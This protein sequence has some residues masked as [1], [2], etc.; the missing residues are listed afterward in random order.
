MNHTQ[1]RRS[2][3]VGQVAI[4]FTNKPI[5]A[6][7]GIASVIAKFLEQIE[8]RSWVE[9]EV[10]I[11]EVSNNG[12]GVYPKVLAQLLTALVGGT[13]FAHLSWW[14]H[15]VEAIKETFGLGWL[16][17]AQSVLTQ[18]WNKIRTQE[19][20]ER[21]GEAAR[22]F[23]VGVTRRDGIEEDDVNFDSSVF[24][25]YGMQEGAKRGYN[26]KKRGRR[27]HHP[28]MAFLGSG[29]VVNLWN[30][31]G[32][33]G[34]GHGAIDFFRQT[35]LTLGEQFRVRRVLCDS[36][37]YEVEFIKHLERERFR[38]IIAGPMMQILQ[39]MIYR[40]TQWYRVDDGIDV[41]EFAFQHRDSKW[42]RLRRY[43]VVRQRVARRPK[44]SGKQLVLFQE[45]EGVAEYRFSIMITN[46]TELSAAEVWRTYRS[47]ANVENA[48][49]DLIEGYGTAAF[50][51]HN[52]WAT[53]SVMVMNAL[54]FHNL[55]HYLNRWVLNPNG[56][57][58]QV[59]TVRS[60]YFI[61]PAQLGRSG[62]RPV[63]RLAVRDRR[64]RAQLDY[65]LLPAVRHGERISALSWNLN[66]I[67]VK[68]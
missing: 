35:L 4:E 24:T 22:S 6:W 46:D 40:G 11:R 37:F 7:G 13:R 58:A 63:V 59:K 55:V 61:I 5:T 32:D 48:L 31:S 41:A 65:F 66:C 45:L 18:F 67:A 2:R 1:Y 49:K 29:Y 9:T 60:K 3:E 28:L 15:G 47:R 25:R 20:S 50:N 38:Y 62:R 23:A 51:M 17:G 33:A 53:E 42:D 43:V 8:F 57:L 39:W 19:V 12:R 68:M 27:S 26:P 34:T 44:A 10:P 56:P 54:V 16:P 52:F 14:G 36:G 64:L 30:R 21:L